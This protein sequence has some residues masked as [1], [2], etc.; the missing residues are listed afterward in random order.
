MLARLRREIRSDVL[1][2]RMDAEE[3]AAYAALTLP[4][5]DAY[6]EKLRT[7]LLR[8]ELSDCFPCINYMISNRVRLEQEAMLD[9]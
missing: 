6:A 4:I 2:Y 5:A 3:L 1:P 7:L 9:N 8:E